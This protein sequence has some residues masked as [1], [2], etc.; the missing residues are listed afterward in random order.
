MLTAEEIKKSIIQL[1][2]KEY[3]K[4]RKWFSERDWEEWDKKIAQDAQTGRLDFFAEEAAREK[5]A[6]IS[7]G[8]GLEPMMNT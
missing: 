8:A 5:M 1:P 6:M 3:R 4:L 2:E 7:S